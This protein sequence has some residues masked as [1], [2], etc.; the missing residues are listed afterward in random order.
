MNNLNNTLS[1]GLANRFTLLANKVHDLAAPLTDEEFW[2]KPFGFG[3]SFGHLVLHLTGNLNYYIGAQIAGTGYVRDRPREFAETNH[4]KK[5]EALRRFDEAVNVAVRAVGVQ[6]DDEWALS[7]TAAGAQHIE[8]RFDM[9]LQC[10]THLDH[11]VGQM[12]YLCFELKR[13]TVSVR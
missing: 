11:H 12:I 3:N 6:S 8:N 1:S 13:E 4:F 10:V 7:Y 2:R 9:V 5:E